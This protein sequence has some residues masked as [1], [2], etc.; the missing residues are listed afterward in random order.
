MR[1]DPNAAA[2]TF[3]AQVFYG[4]AIYNANPAA[5]DTTVFINTPLTADGLGNVFFGFRVTNVWSGIRRME[6]RPSP[7]TMSHRSPHLGKNEK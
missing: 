6:R 3:A 1:T 2:G 5:F 4:A 7:N